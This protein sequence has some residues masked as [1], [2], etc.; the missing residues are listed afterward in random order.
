MDLFKALMPKFHKHKISGGPNNRLCILNVSTNVCV[1][2]VILFKLGEMGQALR[3]LL[4]K[5]SM[6]TNK[7]GFRRGHV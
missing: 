7:M 5:C 4:H 6:P 2:V 3:A 1:F